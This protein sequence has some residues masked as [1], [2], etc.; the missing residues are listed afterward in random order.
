M[1]VVPADTS[2]NYKSAAVEQFAVASTP[3][4]FRPNLNHSRLRPAATSVPIEQIEQLQRCLLLT[5]LFSGN[6]ASPIPQNPSSS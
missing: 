2:G 3:K 4:A 1:R 6:S 5:L